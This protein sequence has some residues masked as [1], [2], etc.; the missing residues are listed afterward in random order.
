MS[1]RIPPTL[2]LPV[3]V[4]ADKLPRLVMF[5]CALATTMLAN[6]ARLA[7]ATIP[8]TLAPC[9]LNNALALPAKKF[10]VAKLPRLAFV[11]LRLPV[12]ASIV[13]LPTVRPF[14]TTKFLIAILFYPMLVGNICPY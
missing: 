7:F 2:A 14:F 9:M 1:V 3:T 8:T 11:T 5:G 13:A 10:A 12:P 6:A 4:S